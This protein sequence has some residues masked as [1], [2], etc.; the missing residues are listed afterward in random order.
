MDNK[1]GIIG[2]FADCGNPADGRAVKTLVLWDELKKRGYADI[3]RVEICSGKGSRLRRAWNTFRCFLKCDTVIALPSADELDKYLPLLC[4]LKK[5]FKRRV[6]HD[7]IGGSLAEYVRKN[8]KS[9]EYLKCFDGNWV[10][11]K[12][13]KNDLAELGVENCTVIA[14]FKNL[15]SRS[16]MPNPTESGRYK[17]CMLGP[18][19]EE[20]GV[21]QAADA[22]AQYNSCHD[23]K[24]TLEIWG[25][26][27]EE[28]KDKFNRLLGE[29]SDCVSYMGSVDFDKS[30][31]ALT[32]H[33]ALL[34]P[35][36]WEHEGFSATIID[37]YTGA[38][39]VIASDW[40]ANSELVKNFE[41]GWVYPN[42][43]ISSLEESIVWA[44]EHYDE[45]AAMRI[46]CSLLAKHYSANFVMGRIVNEIN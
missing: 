33:I 40:N 34:F 19:M 7:V 12:K 35:T 44:V 43:K 42:D 1:I 29:Y 24:V 4:R 30:V 14:N 36:Q 16:A 18:V 22:I 3:Y 37:A 11:F 13:L 15:N 2:H 32:D 6:F 45:M 23:T 27:A 39:P 10:E 38:V 26:V 5:R 28:Y 9:A 8:P 21:T 31:E 20:K 46:N 41:T 17:F 25:A